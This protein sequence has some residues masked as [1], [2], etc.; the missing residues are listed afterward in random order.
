MTFF[1]H[2][3]IIVTGA[4]SGIGR[5]TAIA[6]AEKWANVSISDVDK[7]G[8][9]ETAE[10]IKSEGGIVHT[11][12][13]D[14]SMEKEVIKLMDDT[15]RVF[16]GLYG[17]CNNAGVSG[18]LSA[19]ADYTVKEWD[20]VMNINLRGQWLCM[21]YQIPLLLQNGGGSIVNVSSILGTVGFENAPAYVAAKHG[22]NG[23]TKTAAL[24]YSSKGIRVNTVAPAFIE[25]P[26]LD[27]A[28]LTS[29][30]GVKQS[31]VDLHPIGRLGTPRE[32]ADAIIWL[33]SDEASFI[34][35][36]TLLVDGGYTA[37]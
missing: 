3:T 24:E 12:V 16:G 25:T 31:I 18:E 2:K 32:V 17:A 4:A 13:A 9:L 30:P 37:V 26:M 6:F 15:V 34:T 1:K 27:N 7:S 33:M 28:G 35:G 22:L 20:R 29:D 14:I 10:I 21:K 11:V 23:L 36:H 8:L 19:T 5:E